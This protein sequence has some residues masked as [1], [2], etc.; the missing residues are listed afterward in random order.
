VFLDLGRPSD[1]LKYLNAGRDSAQAVNTAIITVRDATMGQIPS[2]SAQEAVKALS[3]LESRPEPADSAARD[4]QRA[5]IRVMEPWRLA[6][7]DTSQTA[8]S[9]QR[10]RSL[11]RNEKNDPVSAEIEIAFLEMLRAE[12]T[13]SPS[14]RRSV[15]RLDS[16]VLQTD[17]AFVQS[18]ARLAQFMLAGAR[19]YEKLGDFDRALAMAGRY[20]VWNAEAMP[21]LSQQLREQGR[22]AVKAG[23]RKRAVRAYN[24]YLG[25]RAKAEAFAQP[26]VDSVRKELATLQGK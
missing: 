5:V 15:D 8:R 20:T 4:V 24:H 16:L 17:I 21:Y 18:T 19:V 22:L 11:V 14:L 3:Q 10:L 7:G 1:A 9:I 6:H 12:A 26:Q 25:M 13:G 2:G 23:D